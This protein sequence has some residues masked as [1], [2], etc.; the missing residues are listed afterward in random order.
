M[1]INKFFSQVIKSGKSPQLIIKPNAEVPDWRKYQVR[2]GSWVSMDKKHPERISALMPVEKQY[3]PDELRKI[4]A[5][6]HYSNKLD[7]DMNDKVSEDDYPQ[8]NKIIR[9]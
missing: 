1:K 8:D 6:I 4:H 7:I 3:G 2:L 5:A 9:L